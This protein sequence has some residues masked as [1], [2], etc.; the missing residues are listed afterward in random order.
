MDNNQNILGFNSNDNRFVSN[1]VVPNA[2]GSMIERMEYLQTQID[3]LKNSSSVRFIEKSDGAVLNGA[4][5]LF[6]ITGGPILV[7]AIVGIVTTIIGGASNGTLQATTTTPAATT[8][9][10]TTVAIDNDAAGT[11]YR[12]IGATGVLT[13]VTNGAVI[14]DPVTVGDCGFLVPIGNISFLGTAARTGNI[15][16]Y[17]IYTPLS[18]N[19]V[20]VAAA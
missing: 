18:P 16:W 7:K 10:S 14:I 3:I 11:S 15:K 13:P 4:D 2:D 8:A 5:P 17:M 20:V 6:T 12:F 1:L 19:S 9:L